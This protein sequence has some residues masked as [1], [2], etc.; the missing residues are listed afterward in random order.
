MKK[1]NL[2]G[3]VFKEFDEVVLVNERD[4]FHE[5]CVALAP[6]KYAVFENS[7]DANYDDFIGTCD[8][9]DIQLAEMVF[10]EGEYLKEG[11]EDD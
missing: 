11:E 1:C 6:I 2:C 7:G 9:E 4:Y 5:A 8:D 10:D 3:E